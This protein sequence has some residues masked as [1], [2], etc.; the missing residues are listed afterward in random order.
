M[1]NVLQVIIVTLFIFLMGS[2]VVLFIIIHKKRQASYLKEKQFLQASFQ[3]ELLKTKIEI[4]EQTLKNISQEIHD[5]IGQ[6]LSLAKLNLSTFPPSDD[7]RVNEKMDHTRQ[8]VSKAIVDMRDLSRSMHGDRV[9]EMGLKNAIENELTIIRNTGQYTAE[10]LVAGEYYPL[11]RQKEMVLFRV[12]QEALNNSIKHS[13]TKSI[14]VQLNYQP[15]LFSISIKDE[16]TGFDLKS[17]NQTGKGIGLKNMQNRA[18]MINGIFSLN[19]SSGTGTSITI[20]IP[21]PLNS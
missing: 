5:N 8:L 13:K 19:S 15:A 9:A 3:Q 18:A 7:E 10:L 4:Q 14:T 21:E 17:L 11:D 16:G 2:F 1:E 12:V 6:V 20:E